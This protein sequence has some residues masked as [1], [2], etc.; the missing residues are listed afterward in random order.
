MKEAGFASIELFTG[1]GGLALGI[2]EAGFHHLA[3][4]EYDKDSCSTLELNRK[5]LGLPDSVP[6]VTSTDAI[7]FD[8][9]PYAGKVRLLAGGVPC[10]PFSFGGKHRGHADDRNLFPAMLRAVREVAPSA[11]IIE[12][13][14]GLLR[15]RFRPYFEYTLRQLEMPEFGPKED[16]GWEEHDARLRAAKLTYPRAGGLTYRVHHKLLN[17]ADFGVPQVRER[18]F[19]VAYRSDL[20]ATWR[21]PMPTHSADRLLYEQWVTGSYWQEHRITKPKAWRVA[22]GRSRPR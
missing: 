13:V 20:G 5:I 2:S 4:I 8:W 18:V 10:Q 12:N 1:A 15:V 22:S 16:E 21:P 11:V 9:K 7:A 14:K 19:I 17:S 3:L 6:P